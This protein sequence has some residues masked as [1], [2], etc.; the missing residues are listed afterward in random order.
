MI[1]F[2]P[3]TYNMFGIDL[4]E[5]LNDRFGLFIVLLFICILVIY[6]TNK[7]PKIIVKY[8]IDKMTNVEF[9]KQEL[10]FK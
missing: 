8:P 10:N 3:T 7:P 6:L 4:N 5:L 1:I 2:F 9:S